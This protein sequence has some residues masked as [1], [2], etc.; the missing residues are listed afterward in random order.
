MVGPTKE[1]PRALRSLPIRS[2]SGVVAGTS[3]VVFQPLLIGLPSTKRQ[4]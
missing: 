1:K 4:M 2:E 3:A